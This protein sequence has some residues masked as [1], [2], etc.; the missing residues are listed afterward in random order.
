MLHDDMDMISRH[1]V[2]YKILKDQLRQ[3]QTELIKMK[4]DQKLGKLE[5]RMS[6]SPKKKM[7]PID[8]SKFARHIK[9]FELYGPQRGVAPEIKRIIKN[10]TCQDHHFMYC[11]SCKQYEAKDFDPIQ[12]IQKFM[13]YV[14]KEQTKLKSYNRKQ[15]K[16]AKAG[17]VIQP[18]KAPDLVEDS[19]SEIT[20]LDQNEILHRYTMENMTEGEKKARER[21]HTQARLYGEED[22]CQK[23]VC[24]TSHKHR[25]KSVKAPKGATVKVQLKEIADGVSMQDEE[26]SAHQFSLHNK[27]MQADSEER[28]EAEMQTSA[29]IYRSRIDQTSK[30]DA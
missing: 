16:A 15:T 26:N 6:K 19:V 28:L 12:N 22:Y 1:E 18:A 3:H 27:S 9:H 24:S 10:L 11:P 30:Q 23:H 29:I 4:E 8:L 7:K 13:D 21:K 17:G 2:I 14:K 20:D 5:R 25:P